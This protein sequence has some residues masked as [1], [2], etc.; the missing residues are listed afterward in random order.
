M[1]NGCL[2]PTITARLLVGTPLHPPFAPWS[3][4]EVWGSQYCLQGQ[5][6]FKKVELF[7]R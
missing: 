2:P 3:Y 4:L 7:Y 1:D 6:A 5:S